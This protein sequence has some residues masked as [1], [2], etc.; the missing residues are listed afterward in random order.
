MSMYLGA[1]FS[2]YDVPLEK[3]ILE[4]SKEFMRWPKYDKTYVWSGTSLGER[5]VLFAQERSWRTRRALLTHPGRTFKPNDI[6]VGTIQ[7]WSASLGVLA[8]CIADFIEQTNVLDLTPDDRK[9]VDAPPSN[10]WAIETERYLQ[11]WAV[12]PQTT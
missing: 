9:L 10:A 8:A 1:I 11:E 2:Y 7:G 6:G 12:G 3:K 5:V 4:S